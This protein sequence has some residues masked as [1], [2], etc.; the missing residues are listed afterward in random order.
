MLPTDQRDERILAALVGEAAGAFVNGAT[1]ATELGISRAAL[2]GRMERL[3]ATGLPVE[4]VRGRGYRLSTT[5]GEAFHAGLI[6]ARLAQ[7]GGPVSLLFLETI[8][9]TNREAERQLA[10]DAPLPVVV[11]ARQQ[12]AGRGR[13]G[14]VWESASRRNLYLSLAWRPMLPPARMQTFTLWMGL[15]LCRLLNTAFAVQTQVKWPNDLHLDGRKLAGI[16]TEARID[17]D[18]TRDLIFGLGLNLAGD[19]SEAPTDLRTRAI[20]LQASCDAPLDLNAAAADVIAGLLSAAERF[21]SED[22]GSELTSHWPAVDAL[23]GQPVVA[24][25]GQRRQAGVAEGIDASGCLRLRLPD[26]TVSLL[27]GGEVTLSTGGD[28]A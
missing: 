16:L 22:V 18:R 3:T 7:A 13:F 5:A 6:A 12:T 17:A 8:D 25:D 23:A 15:S 26:G 9:S 11:M 1:L 28:P 27:T 19:F 20:S 14:R 10:A 24:T 2:S 4:A 21:F